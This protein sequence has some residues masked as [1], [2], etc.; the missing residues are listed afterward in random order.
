MAFS[1]FCWKGITFGLLLPNSEVC[2]VK[3][4]SLYNCTFGSFGIGAVLK[5]LLSF[6]HGFE[7]HS[8]PVFFPFVF[9][10]V[11]I[12]IYSNLDLY[13]G[14]LVLPKK[15]VVIFLVAIQYYR[16]PGDQR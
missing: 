4:C 1:A 7:S 12:I 5:L 2:I 13:R 3:I 9:G 11:I 6:G 14:T 16:T 10:L 15:R 8:G